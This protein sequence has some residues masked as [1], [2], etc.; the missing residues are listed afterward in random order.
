MKQVKDWFEGLMNEE[1]SSAGFQKGVKAYR[2]DDYVA[3]VAEWTPL[4]EVGDASAQAALGYMY[5]EGIG[6]SQDDARAVEWYRRAAEGDFA[7]AQY[8]AQFALGALSY[9]G[10]NDSK[11]ATA[12]E[13]LAAYLAGDYATALAIWTPLAEAGDLHAQFSLGLMYADGEGVEQDNTEA[14]KW[15]RLAAEAGFAPAQGIMQMTEARGVPLHEIWDVM[16]KRFLAEVKGVEQDETEA[17]KSTRLAAEAGDADAQFNL[18]L[19]YRN[20]KGVAQDYVEAV[21]WWRLAAE[22]GVAEAQYKMGLMYLDGRGVP[23]DET[24]AVKWTRLAAEAGVAEAQY[25]LGVMYLEGLGV[26]QDY[27]EAVKWTRLAAEAGDVKAQYNM[28]SMYLEGLGVAQDYVEA[29]KWWRLAAEAGVAEAQYTMGLMYLEGLGVAQDIVVAYMW[30]NL[31]AAQGNEA[32]STVHDNL[33]QD[34]TPE[35]IAEAEKMAKEMAEKI[36]KNRQE[37]R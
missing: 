30:F 15:T 7:I 1:N 12:Q 25:N 35:Q 36:A 11:V 19:M 4:A 29:V 32:A 20:G 2:A 3:A 23:Q 21:K 27:V 22:A 33:E 17:V 28:G 26:A 5:A 14:V 9:E 37:S 18:G 8:F 16:F 24:E 13:G 34:M 10:R 31:A 6:I